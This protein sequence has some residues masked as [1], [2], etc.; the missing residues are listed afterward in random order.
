MDVLAGVP[1]L[2]YVTK[3]RML[4]A[5]DFL[6]RGE[7]TITEIAERVGYESEAS[8]SKAS[9]REMGVAPGA[10]RRVGQDGAIGQ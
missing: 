9:K 5:G 1:P 8:F 2:A 10:Y 3:W 7:A 6:R 4:K